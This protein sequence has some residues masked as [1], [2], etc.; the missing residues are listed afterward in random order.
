[1]ADNSNFQLRIS[2][3]LVNQIFDLPIGMTIIGREVGTAALVINEQQISRQHARVE[4]TETACRI[5]DVST[6]GTLLNGEKLTRQFVT[7]LK[8]GDELTIGEHRLIFEE[9]KVVVAP[10]P[11]PKRQ[12]PK[13]PPPPPLTIQSQPLY[14]GQVP[15]G[16]A[17]HSLRLLQYLPEIYHPAKAP[18][19]VNG[20]TDD[21]ANDSPA[22]FFSRFLAIFES[23]LLP[24]EWN[25]D[26]FDLFLTVKTAPPEFLPWLAG[27]FDLL[28][29]PT[30]QV[31]QRR[32]ILREAHWLFARRGTKLALARVLEIYTNQQPVILDEQQ[33]EVA[34]H[35]FIVRF[36]PMFDQ[37]KRQLIARLIDVNKP[38][39][40][41]YRLEFA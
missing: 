8:V 13:A 11:P 25:V 21:P 41:T 24:L 33:D 17:R 23:V 30:W 15:P 9:R 28:F 14:W 40:T 7:P 34:P 19:L 3:P 37:E 18:R 35:T 38:A 4:C 26:N 36:P 27:W 16:L 12:P 31:E 5:T 2:G 10:P 29:D 6:Y 39:H 1:M 22:D 20:Q 32:A